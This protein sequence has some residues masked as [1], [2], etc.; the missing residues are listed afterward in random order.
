MTLAEIL[1]QFL[2]A[3]EAWWAELIAIIEA[4]FGGF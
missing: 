2:A 1:E 3:L 4:L